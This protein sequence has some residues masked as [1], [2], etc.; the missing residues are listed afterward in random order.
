[1]YVVG[2]LLQTLIVPVVSG[3]LT[4]LVAGGDPVI[5][6]GRWFLFW[7]LGTRLLLAGAV[8]VLRPGFTLRTVL[9]ESDA[10]TLLTVQELGFANLA[11]GLV[12]TVGSFIPAWWVPAAIPGGLF[13]GQTGL[14]HVGRPAKELA[15]RVA[16]W[17]DLLVAAA[18]LVFATW[19]L[20]H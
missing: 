9:G 4:L 3:A 2:V 20:T 14:R 19:V 17:T 15:E 5:G 6:F 8:Q 10:G 11:M 1:V 13:M 7:G 12:A 16:T 18:M